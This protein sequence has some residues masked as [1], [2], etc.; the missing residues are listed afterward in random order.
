MMLNFGVED[1][2]MGEASR[3]VQNCAWGDEEALIHSDQ[4]LTGI[5]LI[6]PVQLS[7][8]KI[9]EG[10]ESQFQQLDSHVWNPNYHSLLR[11]SLDSI[12]G[13]NSIE[14]IRIGDYVFVLGGN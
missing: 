13:Q 12:L 9:R 11:D 10:L 7:L 1:V 3:V 14:L 8:R 5:P 2:G 6:V 4:S